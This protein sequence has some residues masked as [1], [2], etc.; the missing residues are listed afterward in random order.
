MAQFDVV[1]YILKSQ[2]S[3]GIRAYSYSGTI[4]KTIFMIRNKEGLD[5][6]DISKVFEEDDILWYGK[7]IK[8]FDLKM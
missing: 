2:F 6:T 8:G 3:H 5:L 4:R 7:D 1:V